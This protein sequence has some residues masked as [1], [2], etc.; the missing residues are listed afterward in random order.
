ML[1]VATGMRT[2]IDVAVRDLLVE[3]VPR[4]HRLAS[5]ILHD[6]TAADD[7]VQEA[8]LV[9]WD[10]RE[11]LRDPEAAEGWFIRILVNV[12]R[13]EL[14][15]R[16]RPR[17]VETEG[18]VE[19]AGEY[20][21]QRDELSRAICTLTVDE[22]TILALRFGRDLTVAQIASAMDLRAGTVKSR[23]HAAL[24]HLRAALEAER[25]REE[26]LR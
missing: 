9:A 18:L 6:S 4:A 1:D 20:L 14:R 19:G 8:A 11:D 21:P 3:G 23:L 7:A 22:Q 25:R 15:R 2:Q 26:A 24:A 16:S 10:K 17:I 5:W 13:A 12:C